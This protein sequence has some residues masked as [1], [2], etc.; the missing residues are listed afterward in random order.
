MLKDKPPRMRNLKADALGEALIFKTKY[1]DQWGYS[2]I[3]TK[4]ELYFYFTSSSEL[5]ATDRFLYRKTM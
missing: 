4:Q 5:L 1:R 3:S 2:V